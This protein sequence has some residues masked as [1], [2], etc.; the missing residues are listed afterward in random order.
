MKGII[1]VE[2]VEFVEEALG[3]EIADRVVSLPELSSGG[4]FT[5]VGTYPTEDAFAM[6]GKLVKETGLS[7]RDLLM[8][9]GKHLFGQLAAAHPEFIKD[10]K[11]PED[12]LLK[13]E[14]HI[15][16]DVKKLYPDADLPTFTYEDGDAGEVVMVYRSNKGLADVCEGLL[17]G[18]FA[19]YGMEAQ[20][21]REDLPGG[22]GTAARFSVR[23]G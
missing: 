22:A 19:Y 18:C 7:A 13:I 17:H 10:F 8:S 4:V 16:V 23:A 1:F 11:R 5:S 21:S 12:L 6:V 9:F 3:P 2:L 14:E 15:H 20:V